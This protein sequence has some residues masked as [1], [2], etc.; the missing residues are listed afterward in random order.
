VAAH[1]T[2]RNRVAISVLAFALPCSLSVAEAQR[3]DANPAITIDV[4]AATNRY[5]I[6]PRIYGVAFADTAALT[7]LGATMNRW[8]GNAMSRYN[9][10][11]STANRAKDFYFENIPDEVAG[12]GKN[13]ES[14]DDFISATRAAGAEP[15]MTIPMMGLL[16]K[17]RSIR[18]GY[19]ISKYGPQD[20]ADFMFRPDCGN[21]KSGDVR[22]LHVNDPSD[23]SAV[24]PSSH[25]TD[26]IQH[27]VATWGAAAN[28]GVRYYSLDNEPGLWSF[29]HWDV[30]PDGSTFD[31][32][33][34]KMEEYGAGIRATDPGAVIT[35]IEE[36]GWSG[37]FLS[38]LDHENGDQADRNAHGGV[39][40]TEWLLQQAH[41]YEQT[42][43]V[44]I[45]DVAALHFYPQSGEFSNDITEETQLRRNRSTRSLWDPN[46]V[47]E[48]WIQDFEGGIVRLIPRLK[49]WVANNYPG[50]QVG[51]TEYNWGAENHINGGTAQADILGI[52]GR[53]RLDVGVRW[54]SPPLQS[55]AYHAFKMYRNYDG[56][57]S[58]FGDL[59]VS[60]VA[61]NPDDVSAFA[62]LRT[63]DRKLTVMVIAKTLTDSTPV[64][65]TLANFLP[66][67]PA[68]RW[69]LDASNAITQLA[70]VAVAGSSLSLT[71]PAQSISLL[72]VPGSY[73]DAPTG[74][75]ATAS[76]TTAATINWTGVSG[77]TSYQIFRSSANGPFASAGTTAAT[78][79]ND[80]TLSANTTYLYKVKAIAGAV[81]SPLS[82]V[83]ATT[84][85]MFTNDPL[86]VGTIIKAAHVLELR[87]AVNAMRA[88]TGLP[89]Q[90]FTD[91]PLVAGTSIKA[92]HLQQLRTALDQARAAIGLS[93]LVYTDPTLAVGVT[94]PKA[95]HV[96]EL[97]N[98][99]K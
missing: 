59:T 51:V 67:G 85:T 20:D 49:E 11:F 43:G 68:Q 74:V 30:H 88:A 70:N 81:A 14:A 76:S 19:L 86:S 98:G 82:N 21:G 52:F 42:H 91:T 17:D 44:R 79:F 96:T 75:I 93:T 15:I 32:V 41:T 24:F 36:W 89:A 10:V 65:V 69:Q 4:D 22:M 46:Y 38:G 9:W 80:A 97:R 29:D 58:R 31:E 78:T 2:F 84:T 71:V 95:T 33:W 12:D 27:L 40:Y 5:P 55:P 94:K 73:L 13:G 6:D 56:N 47:D 25:Q 26:W 50:T 87:T 45:L 60:T 1:L 7:D 16:P 92:V 83:D 99:V 28:G 66:S 8:G 61:P 54:I 64:T 62:A 18:C 48:S 37:Y 39:G 53:E 23:T 63:S 3:A 34:S 90:V 77:A 72:V 57:Q 35:G